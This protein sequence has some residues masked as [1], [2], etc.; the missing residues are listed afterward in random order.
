MQLVNKKH[1]LCPQLNVSVVKIPTVHIWAK[2]QL[3]LICHV[4]MYGTFAARFVKTHP[5]R[6]SD[7]NYSAVYLTYTGTNNNLRNDI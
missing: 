4:S 5:E 7:L 2:K 3:T 6:Y 1:V